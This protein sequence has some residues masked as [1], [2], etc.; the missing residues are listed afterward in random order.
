VKPNVFNI[1][2]NYPNPSNPKSKIDFEIPFNGKVAIN[3][4]DIL[5]KEVQ[6]LIDEIKE[7]GYYSV[8]FD[9]SN[10]ASGVYFYRILAE[11][12]AQKFTK[13]LKMVLVK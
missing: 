13:T 10:L 12:E 9:G 8:E 11:G 3:V 2:Q 6:K 7:A 1:S 4:Y 5:G